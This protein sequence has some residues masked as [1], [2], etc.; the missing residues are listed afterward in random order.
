MAR[1]ALMML[2]GARGR[3]AALV[4]GLS[5]AVLL[6]TQQ[7]AIFLGILD[8]ATGPLQNI[9]IADLWVASEGT[10]YVDIVRGIHQRELWRMRSVP[11]VEWAEPLIVT[12]AIAEL[13]DGGFH[14]VQVIG[15]DR[16]TMVG[17]PPILLDG[18][19]EDVLLP[20]A[21]LVE[22]T[23]R[24]RLCNLTTGEELRVNQRRAR[25]VGVGQARTGILSHP[26]LYTTL[27]NA[28]RFVPALEGR[29]T[30]VLVGLKAGAA[31][32]QVLAELSAIPGV[33]VFTTDEMRW[34]SKMYIVF[35]TSIGLNFAL[36]VGLGLVVGLIVSAAAFNQFT[37]ENLPHFAMLKAVGTRPAV[38]VWLVLVQAAVAGL[39]GYGIGIGLA[40][41]LA[42]PGLAPDAELTSLF[43]WQLMAGGLL[44][45]L[46]CIALG[47]VISIRRVIRV[48]PVTLFQ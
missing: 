25:V 35:Q 21:V 19:L 20:E 14:E 28:R 24:H 45:M 8:R 26:Q 3:Y 10:R 11:G 32:H 40:G 2:F 34:R 41:L 9:G 5:F 36:T 39:I 29:M 4:F 43:P 13:P 23:S 16:V 48:D 46:L 7:L 27:E 6:I 42:I 37:G 15:F 38:L 1:I 30:Q 44:P 18:R 31:R 33:A 17:R 12:P 22:A 47:S